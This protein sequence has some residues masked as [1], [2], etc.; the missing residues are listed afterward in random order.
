M[1][2]LREAV[3]ATDLGFILGKKFL[4]II[5]IATIVIMGAA[6]FFVY[7]MVSDLPDIGDVKSVIKSQTTYIYAADGTVITKLFHENRTIVP[8]KQISPTLQDAVIAV[9]DQRFYEHK[10]VDYI[11]IIGSLIKDIRSGE[12]SQGGSTIT[13]QYVKTA[14]FSPEKTISRKIK[15]AFLAMKLERNYNKQQIL[16]KYLNSI[17][18]GN[19]AY[20]IEAASQSYFG[21]P[22][23]KLNLEQSALLAGIIRS[24]EGCNPYKYPIEALKRRNLVLDMMVNQK[25]ITAEQARVAK[26][27]PLALQ[28]KAQHYV[29]IAPYFVEW[30]KAELKT[31]GFNER[32]VYSQGLRVYTT[33]DPKMQESAELAWKKYLPKPKDPDVAIVA[34]NPKKGAV[35]AMVGGKD[36]DK[37]KFNL[38]TQG[39]GRQPGSAFKP[40]ALTAA[41]MN[42]ISPDDGFEA[43]SPAT[44]NIG[45]SKPWT[46][47]NYSGESGSGIMKLRTATIRSVNVVYAG[48]ILKV[49]VNKVI[50]T[51]RKLGITSDLNQDPAIVLGGLKWGVTPLEMASAYSTLAN[52]GVY[53][54]PFGVQKIV[55]PDGK[56]IYEH[57]DKPRQAVDH[58]VAYLVTD[59]LK[60]VIRSG[61]GFRAKI[62][63]PAAGKTGTTTN[64]VD[65]WFCGY[66]PDLAASVWIGY[67][68]PNKTIPM[69]NVHGIHVAGGTFPAQIWAAFM[70]RALKDVK[71]H[72]FDRPP[73]GSYVSITLCDDT[74]LLPSEF[75]PR[76]S[77][78]IFVKKYKPKHIKTCEVHQPITVPNLIGLAEA[79]AIKALTDLKLGYS[80]VRKP[81]TEPVGQVFAQNPTADA[82]VKEGTI[83]EI[84]VS[85]GEGNQS[86]PGQS[87]VVPNVVGLSLEEAINLLDSSGF[88][89]SEEY[90][91][92]DAPEGQVIGQRPPAGFIAQPGSIIVLVVSGSA[93]TNGNV[94]VPRVI[95]KSEKQAK[96][97]L[98]SNGF[99]VTVYVDNRAQS[100]LRYG[101][102]NVSDQNPEPRTKAKQGSKVI[103]YVT[104]GN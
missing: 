85:T 95:G 54:K 41:I 65:A 16:E 7:G 53:N 36:F 12:F 30:I 19:G 97:I 84:S 58:E 35:V 57:E 81:S 4:V 86:T 73:R 96:D 92:S 70:K 47:H 25:K 11:R 32:E 99:S 27:R 87:G 21:I 72:D 74:N 44:F 22:A 77:P 61:T 39:F 94:I 69:T 56:V 66:T 9:E 23:S 2:V 10:G 68:N 55:M 100:I 45:T 93:E 71:T 102:G 78:H 79:N 5:A 24:P 3:E 67:N 82:Q 62:G 46:V 17:Y 98:E 51:A 101:L 60:D 50:Q 26:S 40:I 1:I 43:S 37:Q 18:F 59:I 103:I 28:P 75:C 64:Y 91:L 89:A 80:V 104:P 90:R 88:L 15:E 33:L 52:N 34:I 29:G 14:Y 49:G 63:R 8:L 20:G 48:L 76:V 31:L 6:G 38:A 13:Q 42:G 83:V